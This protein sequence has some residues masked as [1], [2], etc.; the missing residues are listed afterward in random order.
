MGELGA[1]V[2]ERVETL[3]GCIRRVVSCRLEDDLEM[4]EAEDEDGERDPQADMY[5]KYD[6]CLHGPRAEG[7]HPPL[8]LQFLKKFFSIIKRRARCSKQPLNQVTRTW[9]DERAMKNG[10]K[11]THACPCPLP[12]M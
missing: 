9:V 3:A 4:E 8:S 2:A 1:G 7:E 12:N 10:C 11:R 6:A 5:A